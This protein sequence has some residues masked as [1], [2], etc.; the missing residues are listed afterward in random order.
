MKH[1]DFFTSD[2]RLNVSD[3]LDDIKQC[4]QPPPS[5]NPPTLVAVPL[6]RSQLKDEAS[7]SAMLL[8]RRDQSER[9]SE[10]GRTLQCIVCEGRRNVYTECVRF[11]TESGYKTSDLKRS[12]HLSIQGLRQPAFSLWRHLKGKNGNPQ[13]FFLLWLIRVILSSM[14]QSA[15]DNTAMPITVLVLVGGE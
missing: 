7:I 4:P 6:R 14:S 3:A 1:Q 8:W 11:P 10:G 12:A 2:I 13:W 15:A 5:P 9:E